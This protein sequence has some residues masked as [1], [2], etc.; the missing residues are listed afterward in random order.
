MTGNSC[1]STNQIDVLHSSDG[2]VEPDNNAEQLIS[3]P[4]TNSKNNDGDDGWS[5]LK[6][7]PQGVTKTLL[8]EPDMSENVEKIIS[9]VGQLNMGFGIFMKKNLN[10]YHLFL[11]YNLLWTNQT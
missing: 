2:P 5:E 1:T 11:S 4:I 10:S 8:Q 6:D 7:C 9:F 3:K